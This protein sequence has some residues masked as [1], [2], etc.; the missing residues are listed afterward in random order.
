MKPGELYPLIKVELSV[1]LAHR[2]SGAYRCCTSFVSLAPSE[3]LLVARFGSQDHAAGTSA[4]PLTGDIRGPMS[5]FVLISSA[6]PPAA[7]ILD[8][9]GNVSS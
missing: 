7:D 4:Y 8:K 6:L 3:R 9:A 1:V 5:V 2:N